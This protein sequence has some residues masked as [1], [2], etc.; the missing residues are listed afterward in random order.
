M[1][2]FYIFLAKKSVTFLW[3]QVGLVLPNLNKCQLSDKRLELN[4]PPSL[5]P[6]IGQSVTYQLSWDNQIFVFHPSTKARTE[7]FQ[8]LYYTPF[9]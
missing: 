3:L 9:C 1:I 5:S 8:K 2:C 7:C 4:K 6:C